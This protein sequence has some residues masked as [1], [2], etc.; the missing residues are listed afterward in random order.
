MNNNALKLKAL[1]LAVFAN[2]GKQ[3]TIEMIEAVGLSIDMYDS[4][5]AALTK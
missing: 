3:A 4:F 1:I 5:F 2:E